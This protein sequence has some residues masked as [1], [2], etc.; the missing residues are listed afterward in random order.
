[1]T[2][3]MLA[4]DQLPSAIEG[5]DMVIGLRRLLGKQSLYLSM[6]RKF[7]SGQKNIVSEIHKALESGSWESAERLAHTLKGVAGNIG[8]T[9]L[10]QLAQA[11]ETTIRERHPRIDIDAQLDELASP[12]EQLIVQLE[13]QLPPMLVKTAV[14][15]DLKKL[16]GI[17]DTLESLLIEDNAEAVDLLEANADLFS[18]AFPL[19]YRQ[20]EAGIRSCR[21][22]DSLAA[23]RLATKAAAIHSP[24]PAD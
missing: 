23:L 16:A 1:V 8:A 5:L 18:T 9:H 6:L 22:E 12:L 7:V 15:V 13:R 17:C 3:A 11:L 14:T 4:A 24:T 10:P 20:I 21:F 19:H 2:A